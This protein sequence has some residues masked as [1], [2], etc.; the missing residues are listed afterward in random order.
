[1]Q[2]YTEPKLPGGRNTDFPPKRAHFV[3]WGDGDDNCHHQRQRKHSF[4]PFLSFF[5][6]SHGMGRREAEDIRVTK[7]LSE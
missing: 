7:S 1:M 6:R 2:F 3:F 4:C 5:G